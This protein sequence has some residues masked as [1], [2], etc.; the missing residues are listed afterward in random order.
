MTRGSSVIA[1]FPNQEKAWC[2]PC[3]RLMVLGQY[4]LCLDCELIFRLAKLERVQFVKQL[5]R[6]RK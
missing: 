3:G 4:G 1:A 5:A 2:G 6:F